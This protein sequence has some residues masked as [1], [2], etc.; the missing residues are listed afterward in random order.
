M[1]YIV[2]ARVIALG[3]SLAGV[4]GCVT[5]PQAV[6]RLAGAGASLDKM[7]LKVARLAALADT[8]S[9]SIAAA[10]V[11]GAWRAQRLGALLSMPSEVRLAEALRLQQ[12][13]FE[14]ARATLRRRRWGS[15]QS[16]CG[17][18][19]ERSLPSRVVGR[20]VLVVVPSM[21]QSGAH[22]AWIEVSRY[23][24]PADVAFVVGRSTA[25]KGFLEARG[26][27]VID[28]GEGLV[29]A[30]AQ[31]AATF[32]AA[33]DDVQPSVVHFDGAEG[34]T[35]A[36]AAFLRGARVVQHVRLNDVDRFRPAFVYA[37]AI[38]GVSPHVC[39]Q[40]EARVG[41]GTRVEHIPD[42]VCLESRPPR[43]PGTDG[44]AT[45]TA[46]AEDE[47]LL[48]LCVGRVEPA[49]G[50]LRVLDIF[51]SLR[52][53]LTCRLVI[54]GP[55]GN[56]A[57]YCDE[58]RDRTHAPELAAD[59]AWEPFT[60]PMDDLYRQA[61]VVLVGSRNEALGMVGLETLAA[62]GLLVAQRS[63]GYECII[64]PGALGG[65][66]VRRA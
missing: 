7:P 9:Q 23:L 52:N 39:G 25:L 59:V 29:P 16:D 63:T 12:Q 19:G 64:N 14:E 31:D 49:K 18:L 61:H 4:P 32:L 28:V 62:G 24:S 17:P 66:P 38:V 30:S 47:S 43:V 2:S 42:G 50:Q 44:R 36:Q 34:N 11:P 21:F 53:Q 46:D 33:L 58:V 51:R 22:A 5:L 8:T 20:D 13:S 35:W 15:A 27:P 45:S 48:C 55:C 26:F 54:V 65:P 6:E 56:D 57:A 41:S 37:A 1:F 3:D 60:Y 10:L 40:I